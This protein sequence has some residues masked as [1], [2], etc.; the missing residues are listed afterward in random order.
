MMLRVFTVVVA[1]CRYSDVALFPVQEL[2]EVSELIRVKLLPVLYVIEKFFQFMSC[3]INREIER[4][5][6]MSTV[7]VALVVVSKL[8]VNF[9]RVRSYIN[10]VAEAPVLTVNCV[11]VF[12]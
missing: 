11:V 4:F 5:R 10:F 2:V 12:I 6:T 9:L 8:W 1:K 3:R 7:P